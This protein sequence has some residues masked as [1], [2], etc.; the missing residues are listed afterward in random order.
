MSSA[1][2]HSAALL[3]LVFLAPLTLVFGQD[4]RCATETILEANLAADSGYARSFF[5]VE[6]ALRDMA[7]T[8][9]RTSAEYTVPVVVHILH[10]G[11]AV[12]VENNL[13]DA[14]I[15]GAID[16]LNAD[17]R[18]EYGGAD[19]D[20][21]FDLAKRDPEGNPST[22][23]VRV[24]VLNSIPSYADDGMVTDDNL[25]PSSENNL[26]TL[27][28]WPKE[29]YINIWVVSGLNGGMS[30]LGVAYLPPVNGFYDGIVLHRRVFGVGVEYDLLNNYDLNKSLTHEM[31]HYFGLYHTFRMTS[32]CNAETNCNSQGD[33]VCDTPATTGSA[34]CSALDCP[35]TMVENFMD[36]GYDQC[37]NSFT[38]GQRTRMRN[39][40][41]NHR[42][43][44][45]E[46]AGL[47]PVVADDAGISSIQGLAPVGCNATHEIEVSIQNFGTDLMTQ[48][49]VNFSLDGGAPFAIQWAGELA[50]GMST[51]VSLPALAAGEGTHELSVWTSMSEDEY[52]PND[53]MSME[54]EVVP[55]TWL[56]M[57]IQFDFLPHGISWAVENTELGTVVL[58]GGNY[59][60]DEYA[61]EFIQVEGCASDGCY[62]LTVEDLFGNGMH[63]SPPGW[64][65]LSDAEANILGEG[66]GN[67]GAEQT[68][69]FCI[70]GSAVEP[71]EDLNGNGLCDDE[72]DELYVV[73]PGCTDP[74]SCTYDAEANTDDGSCDYLD[75]LGDCGGDCEADV[76]GDGVCD[77][78]EIPGCTD[79][80][81]C[82]FDASATE[83]NGN[84]EYAAEGYDC[85]GNPL[86]VIAGCTDGEACNY[87]QE[88]NTDD[89]SC[90]YAAEGYDCDGNALVS[91]VGNLEAGQTLTA[92]PNPSIGGVFRIGGF[93]G[94]GPH[95]LTVLDLNGRLVHSERSEAMSTAAGWSLQ[96]NIILKA[97]AYLVR[98][99]DARASRTVRVLVH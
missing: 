49:V 59:V 98:V 74:L 61:S 83:E 21:E 88:A 84:C 33:Q 1:I 95:P 92:F 9:L 57:D 39:S 99:G 28:H 70:S 50:P 16:A 85:D 46:S 25:H 78:L 90:E 47:V 64:Y 89:G 38:E 44:L 63:Y 3:L 45:L 68:H 55:G 53:T 71:C 93:P 37:V 26:K 34:G 30:P 13:S 41:L 79:E 15:Q 65:A 10:H 12:G 80:T 56:T 62:T 36:Y 66:S 20:I 43:S 73:V 97:G 18:G 27:S 14:Q 76:D 32:S 35:D 81:A 82:N 42:E 72:E 5:A 31:G 94:P 24:N 40:L 2:R 67:F 86:E 7:S 54:F 77:A 69:N 75:A 4:T 48:A 8:S 17:F 91:S 60:N 22:G 87:D 11:E 29:D 51:L 23:I 6:A 96:P 58:E 52:A 19:I